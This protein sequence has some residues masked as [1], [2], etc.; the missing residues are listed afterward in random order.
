MSA[1]TRASLVKEAERIGEDALYSSKGHFNAA[2]SWRRLNYGLGIPAVTMSAVAGLSAFADFDKSNVVAGILALLVAVLTAIST[3]LNPEE[4]AAAH[5][6]AGSKFNSLKNRCRLF[7]TTSTAR[8]SIS[9]LARQL[10]ELSDERDDLNESSPP[11][12]GRAFRRARKGIEAGE[13]SYEVDARN[14]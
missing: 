5:H 11:I 7:A 10:R 2:D 3:F 1:V 14:G 6:A 8:V 9:D 12:P 13:A 4:Q